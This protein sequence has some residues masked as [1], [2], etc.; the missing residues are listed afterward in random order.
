MVRRLGILSAKGVAAFVT[1]LEEHRNLLIPDV[2]SYARGR[3]R[4][5]LQHEWNLKLRCFQPA[6]VD[7]ELWSMCLK[8]M[9]N[10]KLG[11]AVH[12]PVGISLHRDDS[13]A[14]WRTV[15]IN[16]GEIEG[17]Q[18]DGQYPEFHWTKERNPSNVRICRVPVGG[19]FAFNCKNPHAALKPAEN[20]WAIFLWDIAPK[21]R[22]QFRCETGGG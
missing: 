6:L 3:Q 12:G 1:K 18:Y 11:L 13:Y 10:A 17:W 16:L 14:D 19:V 21:F 22:N 2:S 5:W 7:Q 15:G 9:P 20:R 4:F 8:W